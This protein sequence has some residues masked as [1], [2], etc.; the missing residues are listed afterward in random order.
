MEGKKQG[1]MCGGGWEREDYNYKPERRVRMG[2]RDRGR[3]EER[4]GKREIGMEG[5][6]LF[7]LL[8]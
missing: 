8:S 5:R 2:R 3:E 6:A 4:E 1:W 7:R